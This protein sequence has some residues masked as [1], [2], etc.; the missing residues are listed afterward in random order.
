MPTRYPVH[1]VGSVPLANAAEVFETLARA[2]GPHLRT[3]PDGETGPRLDWLPWL[4]PIFSQH[5]DF[6]ISQEQFRVHAGATPFRRYRLA[7]GVDPNA[8]RFSKLPHAGFALDSWKDFERLKKAGKIPGR[9]RYQCDIASIPSLLAAFVVEGLH[10]ALEPALEAAVI[11]EIDTIC[12]AIP[13]SQLAIQYDVAS[14]I[15]FHLESGKPCRFGATREQMMAS[16]VPM[17]VRLGNAVPQEVHLAYHLC[18]GDNRHRHSIEPGDMSHLVSFANEVSAEIGR[19]IELIHMP[20]PRDRS[21][22]AYFEPLRRLALRPETALALGLVHYTGGI[23][24][25][26][27]RIAT[28]EKYVEGFMIGTECGFGRRDPATLAELL[29]IHALAAQGD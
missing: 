12:A 14:S 7:P 2:L 15:F 29:E 23:E 22:D 9:V 6:E 21:D 17:H 4:E 5:P 26:R 20:V 13:H 25:T 24:G 8:V 11:G 10:D 27:R 16:F 18:Y 19:T 28:A 3:L 1:I